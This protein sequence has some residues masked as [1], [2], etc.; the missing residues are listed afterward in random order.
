[1]GICTQQFPPSIDL[2]RME[3]KA[4][5]GRQKFGTRKRIDLTR[6]EC[7]VNY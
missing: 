3:C 6:M 5:L 4:Y 1:M 2:T 7:K